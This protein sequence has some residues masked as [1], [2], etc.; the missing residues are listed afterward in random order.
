M[1]ATS[2]LTKI[3]ACGVTGAEVGGAGWLVRQPAVPTQ[4]D[5]NAFYVRQLSPP[6]AFSGTPDD[7]ELLALL[8]KLRTH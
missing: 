7:G 6:A 4:I 2:D 3:G 8:N 5:L 1:S